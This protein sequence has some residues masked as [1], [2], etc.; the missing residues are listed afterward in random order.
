LTAID[1]QHLAGH[2]GSRFEVENRVDK[3]VAEASLKRLKV[4]AIAL[5]YQH[6]VDPDVAIE[7]VAGAAKD[8]IQQGKVK[9]FGLSEGGTVSG[10]SEANG[11]S[12]IDARSSQ[13]RGEHLAV[14]VWVGR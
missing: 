10:T 12:L 2:K 4:D 1:V 11:R 9:H 8:L 6:R 5:S 7:D 3:E 13:G 14:I